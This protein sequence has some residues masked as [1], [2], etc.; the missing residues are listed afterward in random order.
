VSVDVLDVIGRQ[1][2]IQQL[3]VTQVAQAHSQSRASASF[4]KG[5]PTSLEQT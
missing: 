3:S 1:A 5:T 4:P 2:D